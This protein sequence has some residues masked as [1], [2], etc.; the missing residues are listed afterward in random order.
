MKLLVKHFL[1]LS[2]VVSV[3][4]ACQSSD[5]YGGQ[6]SRFYATNRTPTVSNEF[7]SDAD[8]EKAVNKSFRKSQKPKNNLAEGQTW[9]ASK[10][11]STAKR[12]TKAEQQT[13]ST[14]VN[15]KK[16]DRQYVENQQQAQNNNR[17]PVV[18]SASTKAP[19]ATNGHGSYVAPQQVQTQQQIQSSQTNTYTPAV[20][21]Y[22]IQAGCYSREEV[23]LSQVAKL[24]TNGINN[25]HII[26]EGGISKVRVGP[27]TTKESGT[28]VLNKMKNQLGFVDSFWKY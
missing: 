13:I 6:T 15:T 7:R 11:V 8:L 27:Y 25:V 5:R 20:G 23:A 22:Y 3:V 10:Q 16:N 24:K 1:C 17:Q 19:N 14:V 18:Y 12:N 9:D 21:Q 26:N 2:I 28:S 4:S